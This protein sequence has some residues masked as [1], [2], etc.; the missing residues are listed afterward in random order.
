MRTINF[1]EKE[2]VVYK[3]AVTN[4]EVKAII[5]SVDLL[6]NIIDNGKTLI[7]RVLVNGKLKILQICN[8]DNYKPINKWTQ[9]ELDDKI[10]ELL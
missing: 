3:R 10:V 7:A 5:S 9:K 1:S 4:E 2:V 8:V 6:S